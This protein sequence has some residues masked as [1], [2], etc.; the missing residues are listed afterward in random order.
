MG[1][2]EREL[3][4][5][6]I[7]VSSGRQSQFRRFWRFAGEKAGFRVDVGNDGDGIVRVSS[8]TSNGS[9]VCRVNDP[10]MNNTNGKYDKEG[11]SFDCRR[12]ID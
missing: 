4:G 2:F 7:E 12:K 8:A 5:I 3:K 1:A 9:C 10:R 11:N 6:G